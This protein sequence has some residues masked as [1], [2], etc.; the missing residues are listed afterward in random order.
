MG[1]AHPVDSEGQGTDATFWKQATVDPCAEAIFPSHPSA[2]ARSRKFVREMLARWDA[3]DVTGTA[4]LV[5]TELVTNAICHA[6]TDAHVQLTWASPLLRIAVGDGSR[7]PPVMVERPDENGGHG[8]HL[9]SALAQSFG[10][11]QHADG[12]VVWCEVV[13]RDGTTT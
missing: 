12:K 4:E 3:D 10:V 6:M 8:L 13:H 9:V 1:E 11:E 7:V 5:T 2:P